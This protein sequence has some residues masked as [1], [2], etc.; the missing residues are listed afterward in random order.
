VVALQFGGFYLCCLGSCL[1]LCCMLAPCV[2]VNKTLNHFSPMCFGLSV[3]WCFSLFVAGHRALLSVPCAFVVVA[4]LL[5]S[6]KL[7]S[8]FFLCRC[9][10]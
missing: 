5:I 4:C 8:V 9:Y 10:L 1:V 2:L 3:M 7:V 6:P